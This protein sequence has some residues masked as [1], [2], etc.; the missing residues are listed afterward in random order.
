MSRARKKPV[1]VSPPST[2]RRPKKVEEILADLDPSSALTPAKAPDGDDLAD[3]DFRQDLREELEEVMQAAKAKKEALVKNTANTAA[4]TAA[5]NIAKDEA[6]TQMPASAPPS[7]PPSA[8]ASALASSFSSNGVGTHA[9]DEDEDDFDDEDED[10]EDDFDDEDEDEDDFDDEDEDDEIDEDEIDEDAFDEDDE[11]PARAPRKKAAAK[12]KAPAKKA[13]ASPRGPVP[14]GGRAMPMGS[15]FG[16]APSSPAMPAGPR[17]PARIQQEK[18]EQNLSEYDEMLAS[19]DFDASKNHRILLH[20]VKPEWHMATGTRIAGYLEEFRRPVTVEEVRAKYGGGEYTFTLQGPSSPDGSGRMSFKRAKTVE[21]A[22]EPIVPGSPSAQRAGAKAAEETQLQ[23]VKQ[24]MESKD[25]DAQRLWQEQQDLKKMLLQTMTKNDSGIKD[26]VASAIN[27]GGDLRREM[28]EERRLQEDRI[29]AEREERQREL[30][31]LA[32]E[33]K[34]ELE[35]AQTSHERSLEMMRL[36]NEKQIEMMRLEQQRIVEELR[37]RTANEASSGRDLLLFMQKMEAEKAATMQRQQELFLLQQQKQQELATAQASKQQEFLLQQQMQGQQML[38]AQMQAMQQTKET[39]LMEMVKESRSKKD[40]FFQTVEKMQQFKKLMGSMNGEEEDTRER[41]EKVL[42]RVGEAAPGIVAVASSFLQSRA[43]QQAAQQAQASQA[44]QAS[45]AEQRVLP[46]SVA[47]AEV[48]LPAPQLP[49]ARRAVPPKAIPPPKQAKPKPTATKAKPATPPAPLKPPTP[50][51]PSVTSTV[52][53]ATQPAA[54]GANPLTNFVFPPTDGSM[55]IPD[56]ISLLVQDIDL[57]I[58]REYPAQ[59]IY[60][61]VVAKFPVEVLTIL[62]L[63]S[64]DQMIEILEQRA[65]ASWIVNSL[66]GSRRIEELHALLVE[67]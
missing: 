5:N 33:R 1:P 67:S 38:M 6:G 23:L 61:E 32:A 41:W 24:V 29:R 26:V 37:A 2:V 57:A 56:A 35:L 63:A 42:D 66:V 58:Q 62:K 8:L 27:G 31:R 55:A 65:P 59:R 19:I 28:M 21:I 48:D 15:P 3:V 52:L 16:F 50:P 39:F 54:E 46:G 4:K 10:V 47:V 11:P 36:Q 49:P 20:R 7:A 51:A 53:E 18:I 17:L 43:Q 30:D 13:P 40:D 14:L 25:R 34:R 45:Q 60:D 12:K 64:A 9:P 44:S 22:G